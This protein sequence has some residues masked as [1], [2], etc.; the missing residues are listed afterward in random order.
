MRRAVDDAFDAT[1]GR[2]GH[3]VAEAA[4][5]ATG[6]TAEQVIDGLEPYLV[7]QAIPRIVEGIRPYL[8]QTVVPG[9][10]DDLTPRLV[11]EAVPRILDDLRPYLEAQL[12]PGVVDALMPHLEESVAPDL[13]D[14]LMPKIEQ[15]VAPQIVDAVLPKIR[16]EIVPVILNDIVDD[17]AVR[18]LIREQ[19]Q[20]LILDSIEAFRGTL[21]KAD[22]IVDSVGR[23]VLRRPAR[24]KAPTALEIVLADS[25]QEHARP[26][27]LA[28][29][30]LASRRAMWREQAAPPAP[31]GRSFAYAGAVTR[32]LAFMIDSF[33]VGWVAGQG[34]TILLS[35][36]ES[37]FGDVPAWVVAG[38]TLLAASLVPLYLAVSYWTAGRS[39]GM[40]ITGLRVC[41][42]D[43]RRLA[44]LRSLVRAWALLLGIA[45]WVATG[46]ITLLGPNRRLVL[47]MLLHTE[48]RYEVPEAQQHRHI[49][50]ALSKI[51]SGEQAA[52][53]QA[54]D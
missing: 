15:E 17:P 53:P 22:S 12:V 18:D 6:S 8:T 2:V 4:L 25:S 37:L 27:R 34:L 19:S 14:A 43:G 24:P 1:V 52:V 51:R 31:P 21:A 45:L 9:M 10:L 47:D 3:S 23:H 40:A 38:L 41:T 16:N 33:L 42:P 44:F 32:L 13:M 46:L 28:V 26:M 11:D 35:L 20:G 30:D 39:I 49:R 29:E 7:E 36:L 50:D 5:D 54:A 48:V